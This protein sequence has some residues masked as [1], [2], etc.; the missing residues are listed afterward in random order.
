MK[1]LITGAAGFIGFHTVKHLAE[2]GNRIIGIDNINNYYDVELKYARLTECGIG[3]EFIKSHQAMQS[4]KYPNYRFI[5]A[6]LLEKEFIDQLFETEHF[7]V[8]CHLAAQ[9]GVRYSIENP[10]VYIDSNIT[11]FLKHP[12]GMPFPSG[13]AFSLCQFE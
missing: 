1:I 12:R 9:A 2:M 5:K 11:G 13:K 3:R 10:Y 6:D 8:V 7:D 4:T